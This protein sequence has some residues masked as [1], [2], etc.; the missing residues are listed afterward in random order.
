MIVGQDWSSS[1]ALSSKPPGLLDAQSGFDPK[2]PTN[3][4]LDCLLERHF[5]LMR[6]ECYLTN[7]F[8]FIK[9]GSASASIPLQDLIWSARQFTLPEIE[10]V[11][12][13]L[14][15]CLGLRTFL[16]L[17]RAV[18]LS[19]SPKMDQ[20]VNLQL[21]FANSMIRCVAHTGALGM[22]NRGRSQVERDWQQLVKDSRTTPTDGRSCGLRRQVSKYP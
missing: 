3:A 14:V 11:S 12:P 9:S 21:K 8:A 4:N 1:D 15:I 13:R 16:A 18:G 5:G 6:S 2:F 7:V 19:E 17:M 10:I 22:N 20:A